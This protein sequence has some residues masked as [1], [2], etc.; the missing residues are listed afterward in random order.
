MTIPELEV[1]RTNTILY[2]NAYSETLAFYRDLLKFE[3]TTEEDWFVEFRLTGDAF[4]SIAD[5]KETTVPAGSGRGITL[6]WQVGD[7]RTARYHLDSLGIEVT[8]VVW[9]WGAWVIL[10]HDPEGNRIELWS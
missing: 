4:L 5:A 2:C 3:I 10:F 9:R 7:V 1:K 8:P 6:S